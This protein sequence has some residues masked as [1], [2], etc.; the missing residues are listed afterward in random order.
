MLDEAKD[1]M[2]KTFQQLLS[3]PEVKEGFRQ[4]C[5]KAH[6]EFQSKTGAIGSLAVLLETITESN[7]PGVGFMDKM[8]IKGFVASA[9]KILPDVLEKGSK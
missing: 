4:F 3:I 5:V 7:L 9:S 1:V 6:A 2:E 8:Q